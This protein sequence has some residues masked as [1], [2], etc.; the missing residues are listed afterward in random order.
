MG[1]PLYV[2][3]CFLSATGA[4]TQLLLLSV[5]EKRKKLEFVLLCFLSAA[6]VG[7]RLLQLNFSEKR[8]AGVLLFLR[9]KSC[10][11]II[12][13]RILL[14]LFV[15]FNESVLITEP[16]VLT[17]TPYSVNRKN[18]RKRDV[19][20]VDMREILAEVL[21]YVRMDHVIPPN[22]ETLNQAVR[23]GL[24]S[25]PPSHMIGGDQRFS[26][27]YAWV[28]SQTGLF[29]RPRLFMPYYEEI[30]VHKS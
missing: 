5:P 4:G 26:R 17:Q 1:Q 22:N 9:R 20:D 15:L 3:L 10:S 8:R 2:F 29:V 16:N 27:V 30:K 7:A 25:T 28:R 6:R 19:N 11:W 13:S 18:G 14:A 24:V 12:I 23:R 21:P